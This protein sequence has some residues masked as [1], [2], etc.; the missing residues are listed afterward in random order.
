M[1][2]QT[3]LRHLGLALPT[4]KATQDDPT[5]DQQLEQWKRETLRPAYRAA[6]RRAHPDLGGTATA[7]TAVYAARDTLLALRTRPRHVVRHVVVV[8]ATAWH[9]WSTTSTTT[10]SGGW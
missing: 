10:T 9:P 1:D 3:A 2:V 7:M 5:G 8:N 4:I 6:A